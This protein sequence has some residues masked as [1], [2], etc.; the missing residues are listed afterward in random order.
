MVIIDEDLGFLPK[1]IDNYNTQTKTKKNTFLVQKGSINAP[2]TSVDFGHS[3]V[4]K[5]DQHTEPMDDGCSDSEVIA[6]PR[7]GLASKI[8]P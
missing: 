4:S 2:S 1:L 7:V 5:G 3:K 8:L 6:S